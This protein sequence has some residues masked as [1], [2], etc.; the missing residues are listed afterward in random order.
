MYINFQITYQNLYRFVGLLAL[1]TSLL[2]INIK[3]NNN[4]AILFITCISSGFLFWLLLETS[5]T[6][7]KSQITIDTRSE[8]KKEYDNKKNKLDL[9]EGAK[10]H[11]LMQGLNGEIGLIDLSDKIEELNKMQQIVLNDGKILLNSG[12]HEDD[13]NFI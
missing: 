2:L 10:N 5:E 9:I 1:I 3:Y 11:Y 7:S 6:F 4:Y 13:D 12:Y 8:I